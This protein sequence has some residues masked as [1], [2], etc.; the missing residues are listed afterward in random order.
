[1]HRAQQ[2]AYGLAVVQS[3]FVVVVCGQVLGYAAC[4]AILDTALAALRLIK[5]LVL[6][7]PQTVE[8]LNPTVM[9]GLFVFP[10]YT[11]RAQVA[12]AFFLRYALCREGVTATPVIPPATY[13]PIDLRFGR[14]ADAPAED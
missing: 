7:R 2:P 3:Y 5:L 14:H 13:R 11:A 10:L 12:V 6:T 9:R 1:M 8:I 4:A